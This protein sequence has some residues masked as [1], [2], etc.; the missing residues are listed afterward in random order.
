M[1]RMRSKSDESGKHLE[2]LRLDAIRVG[3]GTPGEG[4][5]LE[6]CPLCRAALAD[7]RETADL[8]QRGPDTRFEVPPE[9]DESIMR[10][11]RRIV[12]PPS[13]LFFPLWRRWRIPAMATAAAA[14]LALTL[15][16]PFTQEAVRTDEATAPT[17][18][19]PAGDDVNGDGRVDILDAFR[20]ARLIREPGAEPSWADRNGDGRVNRGDVDA[21][22]RRAVAL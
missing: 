20:M 22:A 15:S 8:L 5:H 7:I 1:V 16:L 17:A 2:L 11:F 18:L 12:R 14:L 21:V 10:E 4:K 19:L 13:P 9:V 3:E 6:E